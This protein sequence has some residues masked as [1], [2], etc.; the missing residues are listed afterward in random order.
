MTSAR[1]AVRTAS[2][3]PA[4]EPAGKVA[5]AG[6]ENLG[7]VPCGTAHALDQRGVAV[8][9]SRQAPGAAHLPPVIG[10]RADQGDPAPLFEGQH[11]VVL[12]RY[13]RLGGQLA[14]EIAVRAAVD[15]IGLV[16]PV[17]ERI[18]EQTEAVFSLQHVPAGLVDP[19][20]VDPSLR[21]QVLQMVQIA[22]RN[23]VPVQ[24]GIHRQRRAILGRPHAVRLHFG[25]GRVVRHDEAVEAHP[26]AQ[27]VGEQPPVA[28]SGHAVDHVEGG[29]RRPGSGIHGRPIG[30]RYSLY[31]RTRL[32]STVL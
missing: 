13:E 23:H 8:G 27:Q 3:N 25:D 21:R 17:A 20:H 24:S 2:S 22:L 29:H 11:P 4:S 16:A 19:L 26:A 1:E 31:M 7:P 32:M 28:R 18:F 15:R 12:Q 14:G 6:A 5:A 9:S 10:R 30:S